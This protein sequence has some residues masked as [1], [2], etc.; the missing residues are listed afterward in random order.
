MAD[1][2]QQ[3]SWSVG[4]KLDPISATCLLPVGLWTSHLAYLSFSLLI[5]HM[6]N[7]LEKM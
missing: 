6:Q 4:C 5:C 3:A 2:T 7:R 1:G